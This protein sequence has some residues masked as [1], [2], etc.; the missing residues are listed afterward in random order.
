MF[1]GKVNYI[2]SCQS[3]EFFF[4]VFSYR[5]LCHVILEH[6]KWPIIDKYQRL[7]KG[8][9]AESLSSFVKAFKSQLFVEG[10]AQ[11]NLTCQVSLTMKFGICSF[12]SFLFVCS[13]LV[14]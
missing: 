1:L 5:D 12:W 13:L 7:L 8:I 14:K 2:F 6:G 4:F 3:S 9:S 10:L 11:G